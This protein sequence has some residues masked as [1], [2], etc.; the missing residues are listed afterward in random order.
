MLWSA[1]KIRNFRKRLGSLAVRGNRWS[2]LQVLFCKTKEKF[3]R[4]NGTRSTV[5]TLCH[6]VIYAIFVSFCPQ[7]ESLFQVSGD[8]F[9]LGRISVAQTPSVASGD[10]SLSEGAYVC[11]RFFSV[12]QKNFLPVFR[13]FQA[14]PSPFRRS[15]PY[16]KGAMGWCDFRLC[17]AEKQKQNPNF[18]ALRSAYFFCGS[19]VRQR[20]PSSGRKVSRVGVTEG[21]RETGEQQ[22]FLFLHRSLFPQRLPSF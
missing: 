5:L 17:A 21:A 19:A 2:L 20:L 4:R 11:T 22:I 10:S 13:C 8:S 1:E 7:S 3:R 12:P 14:N 9:T 6:F 15:R 16:L 18:Q